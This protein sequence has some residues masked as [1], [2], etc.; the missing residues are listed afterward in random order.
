MC[1]LHTKYKF[2]N[3]EKVTDLVITL[4]RVNINNQ[5]DNDYYA[6]MNFSDNFQKIR[7]APVLLQHP[8]S[9]GTS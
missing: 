8:V 2:Q 1:R 5:H 3:I 4:K 6:E 9:A 7:F